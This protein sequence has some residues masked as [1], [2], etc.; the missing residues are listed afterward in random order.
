M[1]SRSFHFALLLTAVFIGWA[2][3]Y[4]PVSSLQAQ[5]PC[6]PCAPC[7]ADSGCWTNSVQSGGWVHQFN[8][9]GLAWGDQEGYCER[10]QRYCDGER[11]VEYGF[12]ARGFY[13]NDQRI[14]FTGNEVTFGAAGV[15]R[16]AAGLRRGNGIGLVYTELLLNQRFDQNILTDFALRESFANNFEIETLEL[17]QLTVACQH[18]NW[19]V[20]IGRF[21]SPFGRYYGLSAQNQFMDVPFIRSE[22]I[23]FRE[24]GAQ[25]RWDPGPLRCA[26]ALTNGGP[27]KDTNSSKALVARVGLDLPRT[28]FGGSV[29]W[30]DGIGSEIQ[31][32][33][34]SHVGVDF[35]LRINERLMFSSEVI[36][37]EYGLRRP[38]IALDDIDWGRSIYNRQLNKGILQP[39][40]GWGYYANLI[41][42]CPRFDW[43][44]SIGQF[45]PSD[46]LGDPI[47]D[48]ITTR[49]L[50]QIY[51]HLNDVL[52]LY[53]SGLI[54]NPV[55]NAQN[56]QRRET[57]M[58]ASGLQI[59]F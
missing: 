10:L 53:A 59:R 28:S 16:A 33:Y 48:Q 3:A 55:D 23:L 4:G 26:V 17:S 50:G 20:E 5:S 18:E 56:G 14:E 29:K 49:G 12:A 43:M 42:N 52:D 1:I 11:W 7:A 54:E 24:T 30:H 8:S 25:L 35:M 21:V 13:L 34:K 32:E 39:L 37:D 31:K 45:L 40:T 6:E 44:I 57:W 27:W 47:H 15:L 38:G 46:T 22:A 19:T 41:G 36:Y 51:W 58:L 2:L 9:P